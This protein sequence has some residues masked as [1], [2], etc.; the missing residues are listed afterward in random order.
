MN[1]QKKKKT[2][3]NNDKD[4]NNF[5]FSVRA[6]PCKKVAVFF[7][8]A[9]PKE[10]GIAYNAKVWDER[11]PEEYLVHYWMTYCDSLDTNE[12]K[13]RYEML[14]EHY[15]PFAKQY[16]GVTFHARKGKFEM[17]CKLEGHKNPKTKTFDTAEQAA[18]VTSFV[19]LFEIFLS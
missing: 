18:R 17:K 13:T 19:Y 10:A 9:T 7:S 6:A 5:E 8:F 3:F 1:H 4:V 11:A 14:R 2:G 15:A 12:K 16:H